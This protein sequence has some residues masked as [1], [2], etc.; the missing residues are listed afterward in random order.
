MAFRV[1]VMVGFAILM[2]EYVRSTEDLPY[3]S[4]SVVLVLRWPDSEETQTS[5]SV[6]ISLLASSHC[7]TGAVK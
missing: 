4:G 2:L 6:D 3:Q 1:V 5:S 7:N